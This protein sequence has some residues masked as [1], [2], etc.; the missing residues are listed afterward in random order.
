MVLGQD[1]EMLQNGLLEGPKSRYSVQTKKELARNENEPF[2]QW[3]VTRAML[4][5]GLL[6]I[7]KPAISLEIYEI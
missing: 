4:Q 3:F 5:N 2:W 1:P 7:Q 6:R